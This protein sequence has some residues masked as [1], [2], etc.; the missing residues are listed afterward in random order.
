MWAEISVC[1]LMLLI[2]VGMQE[3]VSATFDQ[4]FI[5][6]SSEE[7]HQSPTVQNVKVRR[8]FHYCTKTKQS[9]KSSYIVFIP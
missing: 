3:S 7:K 4:N 1:H 2:F 6:V 8:T 5:A 9:T